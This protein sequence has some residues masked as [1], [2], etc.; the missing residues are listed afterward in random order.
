MHASQKIA[1]RL[2]YPIA[3]SD[4]SRYLS[5]KKRRL[6]EQNTKKK[7]NEDPSIRRTRLSPISFFLSFKDHACL[8]APSSL[9]QQ[10]ITSPPL[11]LLLISRLHENNTGEPTRICLLVLLLISPTISSYHKK[12]NRISHTTYRHSGL[13]LGSATRDLASDVGCSS[14]HIRS[15]SIIYLSIDLPIYLPT[16]RS[17]S[18][19]S[20]PSLFLSCISCLLHWSR[21]FI[22]Y[23]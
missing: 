11:L 5:L 1:S 13:S 15:F 20:S 12:K 16:Y 18:L 7:R 6:G 9:Q 4:K 3:V 19:S 23:L 10:T 2:Y 8:A 22:I 14:K 17:I 21:P